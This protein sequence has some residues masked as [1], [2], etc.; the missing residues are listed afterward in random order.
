M[1]GSSA[2]HSYPKAFLT[3]ARTFIPADL[4]FKKYVQRFF[5]PKTAGIEDAEKMAIQKL[6]AQVR[7]PYLFIFQSYSETT[8]IFKSFTLSLGGPH[9]ERTR[10]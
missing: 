9:P 8:S 5:V 7:L 4:L 10:Q 1:S 2:S 6:V 3:T